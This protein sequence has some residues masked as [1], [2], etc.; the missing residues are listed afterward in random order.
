MTPDISVDL[1]ALA[2][3]DDFYALTKAVICGIIRSNMIDTCRGLYQVSQYASSPLASSLINDC[4]ERGLDAGAGG[5]RYSYVYPCFPGFLNVVDSLAAVREAVYEK[6]LVTLRELGALLKSDFRDGE[7]LRQFM[8][9]RCPKIG[10]GD[11]AADHFGVELFELIRH[12]LKKYKTSVNADFHPSYFAWIKHGYM[13]LRAAATPDGRRQGEAL[14]E[15]LGAVRGMDRN[16]PT[17]VLKSIEKIDQKYGIGGIATNMRF[18]KKLMNSPEGRA[19]VVSYIETFMAHDC[20]EIQFNVVD[21]KDLLDAKAHPER[22]RTLLVRV[23][24]YSD[25]FVNL[26][27][28]IQDEIIKRSE[29]DGI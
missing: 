4:L 18:S 16:G 1:D 5:A 24:G 14:S 7:R 26:I 8:L 25:Y 10:N 19:A 29:H 13:G 2:T 11:D 3:F 27:P 23:A 6:H 15:S 21:Q 22:H 9:N 17:G 20:F 28:V 12:E